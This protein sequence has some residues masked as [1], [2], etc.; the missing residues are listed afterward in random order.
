VPVVRPPEPTAEAKFDSRVE[1][2]I[3]SCFRLADF[4]DAS[5]LQR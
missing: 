5:L 4:D 1:A 2:K 3:D